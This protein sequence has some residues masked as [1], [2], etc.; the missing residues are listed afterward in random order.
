MR[1]LFRLF[2][3]GSLR[4]LTRSIFF[5]GSKS[6]RS[7][8]LISSCR[9]AVATARRMIRDWNYLKTICLES[10]DQTIQLILRWSSVALIPLPNETKPRERNAR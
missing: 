2:L 4:S 3:R 9:I 6:A 7:I 8:R 5:C 10:A 1:W